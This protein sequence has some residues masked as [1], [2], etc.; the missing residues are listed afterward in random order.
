MKVLRKLFYYLSGIFGIFA[1]FAIFSGGD[2]YRVMLVFICDKQGRV[3][4]IP[5][6]IGLLVLIATANIM[7]LEDILN[8]K[9]LITNIFVM[10]VGYVL[11]L[12]TGFFYVL[13]NP[14]W[15]VTMPAG[16]KLTLFFGIIEIVCGVIA[17]VLDE[18]KDLSS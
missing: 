3:G 5:S 8:K 9:F 6:F 4:A 14:A 18:K 15:G 7:F 11:V 1:F 12:I 10:C 13:F 16:Y 2:I 17:A